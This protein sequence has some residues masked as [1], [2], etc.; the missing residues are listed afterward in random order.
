[1][2]QVFDEN[3]KVI[4]AT[5]INAGPITALQVK[6]KEKDGYNAVVFGFGNKKEKNVKKPQRKFGN[7][8]CLKEFRQK[9]GEVKA[10][11]GAKT[12]VSVFSEGDNVT[13]IGTSKGRGFQG[14]VKRYG[15]GGGKRTH[16]QRH[17][18]REPGT[19]GGG[20]RTR[21]PSGMRMAGRMG[22][23]RVTIKNLKVVKID[24]ENNQLFVSG[25]V[26]GSRGSLLEIKG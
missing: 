8:S 6:T 1:M 11:V 25:A 16:G 18:E 21:V 26:P 23:D 3:G 14:V 10:E 22:S 5:I 24:K 19:I 9:N 2:T 7:F 15:F 20:L 17:S 13:I 12:D 4:P